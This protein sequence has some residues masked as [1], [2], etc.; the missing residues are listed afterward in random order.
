MVPNHGANVNDSQMHY[1]DT[2]PDLPPSLRG[3]RKSS[4]KPS[5]T[6]KISFT[7]NPLPPPPPP[8]KRTK[9]C[10]SG[11]KSKTKVYTKHHLKPK[12]R[13]FRKPPPSQ[14]NFVRF[15]GL[16]RTF[17]MAPYSFVLFFILPLFFLKQ[18]K[19]KLQ[20]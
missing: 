2:P 12:V 5:E 1:P 9:V 3:H 14:T 20:T 15:T 8:P 16:L 4:E 18:T 13:F 19:K 11:F 7:R 6:N 17:A 10:T